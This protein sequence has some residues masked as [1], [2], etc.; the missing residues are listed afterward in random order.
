MKKK[1]ILVI[2]IVLVIIGITLLVLHKNNSDSLQ[3]E[4][5]N[6]VDKVDKAEDSSGTDNDNEDE[7]QPITYPLVKK[8][9]KEGKKFNFKYTMYVYEDGNFEKYDYYH[10]EIV[11]TG[12]TYYSNVSSD[13]SHQYEYSD[14]NEVKK[15]DLKDQVMKDSSGNPI[16]TSYEYYSSVLEASGY[17]CD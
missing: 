1:I 5:S 16:K 13:G 7:E 6:N 12:D 11:D 4:P 2:F 3:N 15:V 9:L 17:T 8:C 10:A 14:T